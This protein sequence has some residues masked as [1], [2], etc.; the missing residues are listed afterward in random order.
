METQE[1]ILRR[2]EA[3]AMH[4]EQQHLIRAKI[5]YGNGYVKESLLLTHDEH[6][7]GCQVTRWGH[8]EYVITKEILEI[9]LAGQKI[10]LDDSSEYT[11]GLSLDPSLIKELKHDPA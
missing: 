9:L 1:E 11:I 10:V 2:I 8:D 5:D 3:A 4:D 7:D 6:R